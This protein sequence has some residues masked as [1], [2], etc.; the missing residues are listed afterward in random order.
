MNALNIVIVPGRSKSPL[1]PRYR[2]EEDSAKGPP[3][4]YGYCRIFP[5]LTTLQNVQ[6]T[7]VLQAEK[8]FTACLLS[9]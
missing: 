1:L 4:Q 9:K 6:G 8:R 7:V 2:R 3:A 5:A